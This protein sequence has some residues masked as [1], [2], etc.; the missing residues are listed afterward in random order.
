MDCFAYS[1]QFLQAYIFCLRF[2][3]GTDTLTRSLHKG[4]GLLLIDAI[5]CLRVYAFSRTPV[6]DY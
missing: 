5:W 2:V 6:C 4:W 3:A 1:V